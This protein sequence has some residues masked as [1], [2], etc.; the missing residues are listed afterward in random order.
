MGNSR[1]KN[2]PSKMN[3]L[4]KCVYIN[5]TE[6]VNVIWYINEAQKI[7]FLFAISYLKGDLL[8]VFLL[9]GFARNVAG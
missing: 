2:R 6:E 8:W 4:C 5:F 9:C 3:P 7:T 1:T